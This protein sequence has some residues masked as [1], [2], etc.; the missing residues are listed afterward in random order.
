ML[1][2]PI[3]GL[4][5][6]MALWGTIFHVSWMTEF[7]VPSVKLLHGTVRSTMWSVKTLVGDLS[8]LVESTAY[9][10][11]RHKYASPWLSPEIAF[12][13]LWDSPTWTN[14]TATGPSAE[15]VFSRVKDFVLVP[16]TFILISSETAL[17]PVVDTEKSLSL[18]TRLWEET[19][20][21]EW[22]STSS[23]MYLFIGALVMVHLLSA[24]L[25]FLWLLGDFDAYAQGKAV[26]NGIVGFLEGPTRVVLPPGFSV[27]TTSLDVLTGLSEEA[28]PLVSIP[29]H[30]VPTGVED[31]E[32][33]VTE[34]SDD[35]A[36]EPSEVEESVL[37]RQLV[38]YRPFSLESCIV[39]GRTTDADGANAD[40]ESDDLGADQFVARLRDGLTK[41]HF[42]I[43]A[44][45]L[46][47]DINPDLRGI[48]QPLL[49]ASD[50]DSST[51]GPDD[52]QEQLATED[53][54]SAADPVPADDLPVEDCQAV[55]PIPAIDSEP[56]S[57]GQQPLQQAADHLSAVN[58]SVED[59]QA[60]DPNPAVDLKPASA[61]QQPAQHRTSSNAPEAEHR[62]P[63]PRRNRAKRDRYKK[64]MYG[65][66]QASNSALSADAAPAC[67]PVEECQA[68]DQFPAV[69][70]KPASTEEQ[71]ALPSA[72]LDSSS[73]ESHP[74]K[75]GRKRNRVGKKQRARIHAS[76]NT[77]SAPAVED[78]QAADLSPAVDAKPAS[79]EEPPTFS[80][81]DDVEA[82][83]ESA[84]EP[85]VTP[86]TKDRQAVDLIPVVDSKPAL[87]DQQ[88]A[89]Q[90]TSS[91]APSDAPRPES[92]HPF[93]KKKQLNPRQRKRLRQWK[94]EQGLL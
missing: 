23:W 6:S 92:Q 13:N 21:F 8:D 5:I 84:L 67:T 80:W 15:I 94:V 30:G 34:G 43:P 54:T 39:R 7:R 64:R 28:S 42:V 70:P 57:T 9:A 14:D 55:D 45:L 40:G 26:I 44:A 29:G 19:R 73:D 33:L 79:T 66:Q 41:L 38:L 48:L 62:R 50:A 18:V 76:V 25:V 35:A 4:Y 86:P 17:T 87:V 91:D 89:P 83:L 3:V 2:L 59:C 63:T 56:A 60:V 24:V 72:P 47:P 31:R 53:P 27:Q 22:V 75:T 88:P 32:V 81:A 71:P 37:D 1:F 61:E 52:Q 78:R 46:R 68:V 36:S 90:S 93:P 12:G 82:E 69:D 74:A 85:A 58:P 65:D 20:S 49:C 10:V 16:N 11:T 51:E 77:D